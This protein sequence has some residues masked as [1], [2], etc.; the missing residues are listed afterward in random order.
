MR[1]YA[2]TATFSDRRD[3]QDN[4]MKMQ[5]EE[6]F[7]R[8]NNFQLNTWVCVSVDILIWNTSTVTHIIIF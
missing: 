7:I 4:D 3:V 2:F 6:W 5:N 8:V 1:I